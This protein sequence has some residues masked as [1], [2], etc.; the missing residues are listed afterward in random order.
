MGKVTNRDRRLY[1]P[2][3]APTPVKIKT[4]VRLKSL[5]FGQMMFKVYLDTLWLHRCF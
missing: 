1:N 4:G 3:L 5:T 2:D